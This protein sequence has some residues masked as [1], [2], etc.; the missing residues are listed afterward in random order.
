[1]P[2]VIRYYK[3]PH[4]KRKPWRFELYDDDDHHLKSGRFA[5]IGAA[6]TEALKWA[7][8]RGDVSEV[9]GTETYEPLN[10]E[11]YDE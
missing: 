6:R 7:S 2:V 8:P 3:S 5:R 10:I 11:K 1:M 4:H 9:Y